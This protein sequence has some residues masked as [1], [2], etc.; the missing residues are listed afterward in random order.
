MVLMS[1]RTS[2]DVRPLIKN[3][4]VDENSGHCIYSTWIKVSLNLRFADH[5]LI[6]ICIYIY[7]HIYMCIYIYARR[8]R[9]SGYK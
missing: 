6:Y 8:V 7:R 5:L 2:D 3:S 9:G 4:G 1:G